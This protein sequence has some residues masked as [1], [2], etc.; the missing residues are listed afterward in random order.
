MKTPIAFILTAAISISAA[1]AQTPQSQQKPPEIAPEDIIRVTTSLVQTDVV[2]TDK[3]DEIIPDLKLE[4]FELY[5]NGKKQELKFMEFVGTESPRRSEGDR[6]GLPSYVEP[7]GS[8]G[9][10]AKDLKRVIA[11]VLDD[12]NVQIQDLPYVRKMLL[13]YVNNKMRDGDLVAI[14]RVVGGKGLLQQFT[15]DRQLLRRAVA[16]ITP[17]VHPLGASDDPGF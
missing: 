14:V 7:A 1:I 17:V 13:D 9:V 2:V 15:T 12:L 11:F 8:P 6:S 16:S 4:D 3:N 5:D 10:S